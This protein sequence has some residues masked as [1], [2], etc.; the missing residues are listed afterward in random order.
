MKIFLFFLAT[1]ITLAYGKS[2]K[3]CDDRGVW[4]CKSPNRAYAR[5]EG[6]RSRSQSGEVRLDIARRDDDDDDVSTGTG[7]AFGDRRCRE[8]M[9]RLLDGLETKRQVD[10]P[11]GVWGCKRVVKPE[12]PEEPCRRGTRGCKG[13]RRQ[14]REVNDLIEELFAESRTA[15]EWMD[16]RGIKKQTK[17]LVNASRKTKKEKLLK[18]LTFGTFWTK[19]QIR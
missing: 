11:F 14:R 1:F 15:P 2:K 13:K 4:G 8:R 18:T 17:K 5:H 3:D 12:A 6:Y 10:C 9:L 7:C 16:T 19:Q